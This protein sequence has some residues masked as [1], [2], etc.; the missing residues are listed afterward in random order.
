MRTPLAIAAV[1]T[2]ALAA[3]GSDGDDADQL[4]DA[5]ELIDDAEELGISPLALALDQTASAAAFSMEMAMGLSMDIGFGDAIEFAA[6]PSNP[7]MIAEVDAEGQQHVVMDLGAM[8]GSMGG[9]GALG[10]DL[11]MEIWVD[12]TTLYADYG[13]MGAM[14][15]AA[16]L[17][18]PDGVFSVDLAALG[19]A[20]GDVLGGADIA[21]SISGQAMPDPVDMANVLKEVLTDVD[22]DG[23]TYSG[24]IGFL[25]YSRAMGQEPTDMSGGLGDLGDMVDV[26]A[27]MAIFEDMAVEVEVTVVDGAADVISYDV[28]MSPMFAGMADALGSDAG[29]DGFGDLFAD[30]TMTMEMIMDYDIDASIDVRLPDGDIP[31]VTEQFIELMESGGPF[32]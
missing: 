18:I 26:D 4:P 22:G 20:V 28:D 2:L 1:S 25:D 15:S 14:M 21:S 10:D 12:G 6:D 3:C 11:G 7:V 13:S 32:S 8:A 17:G 5:D 19:E 29:M 27:L 16:G 24:T 23:S 30:A 31:D 9:G